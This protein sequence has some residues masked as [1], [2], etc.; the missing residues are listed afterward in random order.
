MNPSLLDWHCCQRKKKSIILL[1][2]WYTV[3]VEL[4]P[5][6]P[7]MGP[8]HAL[9]HVLGPTGD[10]LRFSLAEVENASHVGFAK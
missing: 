3:A 10:R 4:S 8:C 1:L 5:R 6:N 7:R 2:P 9:A